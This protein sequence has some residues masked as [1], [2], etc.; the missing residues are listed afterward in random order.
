M[1][2]A[3]LALCLLPCAALAQPVVVDGAMPDGQDFVAVSFTVPLGTQEIEILHQTVDA[4]NILDWGVMSPEGFRGYGGGNSENAVIG[5]DASSRSYLL[6]PITPGEWQLYIGKAKELVAPARYHLE[7]TFRT[8]PTLAAQTE[9]SPYQPAAARVKERRWYAGD[10]HCHS[11]ESGDAQPEIEAMIAL[12]KTRGLD[13]IELSDHNTRSQLD[14]INLSQ[15]HHPDFL[16]LPGVEWTSYGGHANGIGV[17]Q[18]VDH[19]VGFNGVTAAAAAA[20]IVA[21][22]AVFSINHPVLDLGDQCIGCKWKHPIPKDSLG[23]MEIG[24]GGWDKTGVLF[25]RQAIAMWDGLCA[26]GLHLAALGGS[27]DHSAGVNE[28]AFGSPIGNPTTMVFAE[29]LSVQGI[30]DA[31]R[32]GHTAVKLQGPGDPMVDLTAGDAH[33]GDTVKQASV[34]LS[35]TVTGGIGLKVRF[36]HNGTPMDPVDVTSDPFTATTV[37]T[38]PA[39]GED[40]W[41][42]EVMVDADPRTVTSHLWVA[43][44]DPPASK[45]CGCDSAGGLGLG[46]WLLARSLSRRERVPPVTPGESTS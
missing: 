18:W 24:T 38:A 43:P 35:A 16:L 5:V 34:T 13:F 2:T 33:A 3:L 21:Q 27:D 10:L 14:F 7:L 12:A 6:G 28:G 22:G 31:I 8:A 25:T 45:G 29:E 30:V 4:A 36:V 41:R 42:A 44:P 37:A 26:T 20:A 32:H 11:K 15:Q 19:R 17:T 23:G 46:L 1:K 39:S 40:R 9:R